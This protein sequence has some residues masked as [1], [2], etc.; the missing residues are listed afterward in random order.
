MLDVYESV[1]SASLERLGALQQDLYSCLFLLCTKDRS[2]P[3]SP[4][5][6]V[7]CLLF[8]AV[9]LP[10]LT[11]LYML[12]FVLISFQYCYSQQSSGYFIAVVTLPDNWFAGERLCRNIYAITRGVIQLGVHCFVASVQRSLSPEELTATSEYGVIKGIQPHTEQ[13][14]F[15]NTSWWQFSLL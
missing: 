12:S 1:D 10:A 6:K 15:S 5:P 8:F 14:S 7:S 2:V 9:L 13:G 3:R 11:F 4:I